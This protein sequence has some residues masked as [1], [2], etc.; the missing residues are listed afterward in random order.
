MQHKIHH[1][2]I[3]L[4]DLHLGSR[5][6]RA[7]EVLRFLKKHSCDK[8][9]LCGDIIDGWSIMRGK[10]VK[11]RRRHTNVMKYLLSIQDTTEIIYIR[12]NHDDFLDRVLPLKFGNMTLAKDYV[13]E[14]HGKKYY[15]VHGDEFDSVTKHAKWLS[16]LGDIGYTILLYINHLYN[17]KRE[18]D[19]LGYKSISKGIKLKVKSSVSYISQFEDQL[20][21][22]AKQKGCNGIICGHVHHA[23]NKYLNDIHYI[24]SGDW[25]ESMSAAVEEY[26]GRW[27][28]IEN[29]GNV[30][31]QSSLKSTIPATSTR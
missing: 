4:S 19:G 14:S 26:D 18:Q 28:I 11:W 13:Y 29:S 15:I 3:I 31:N 21:I 5:W 22:I 9:I 24:N 17:K 30:A 10:Q 2:T 1:K 20:S 8:L 16:K 25:V 12:G 27:H 7:S 6:S 23:E